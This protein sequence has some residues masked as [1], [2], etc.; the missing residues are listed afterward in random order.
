MPSSLNALSKNLIKEQCKNLGNQFSGNRLDLL[1]RKGVYPYEFA[2]SVERLN[3]TELPPKSAFYSK[4][5]DSDISDEDYAHAKTVWT[6]FRC[7]TLREYH[8][9]YNLSDV[10]LLADVFETLETF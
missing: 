8:E 10:L 5:N 7:K 6:E 2:E 4:L 3:A 1:L 9:L